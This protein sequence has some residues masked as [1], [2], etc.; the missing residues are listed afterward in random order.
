M[1]HK[2]APSASAAPR[3]L[4]SRRPEI[5]WRADFGATGASEWEALSGAWATLTDGYGPTT[6]QGGV[7]VAGERSWWDVTITARVRLEPDG[8]RIVGMLWGYDPAEQFVRLYHRHNHAS[9]YF[10]FALNPA[11]GKAGV[12][13]CFKDGRRGAVAEV[14]LSL[15]LASEFELTV[16]TDR[17]DFEA[18]LNGRCILRGQIQSLYNQVGRVGLWA[19]GPACFTDLHVSTTPKWALCRKPLGGDPAEAC[20][21]DAS[22]EMLRDLLKLP[23]GLGREQ[24]IDTPEL[25]RVKREHVRRNLRWLIGNDPTCDLPLNPRVK[26]E[27]HFSE[28][29]RREIRLSSTPDNDLSTYLLIPPDVRKPRPAVIVL[30]PT[31]RLG[32]KCS[33]HDCPLSKHRQYAEDLALRGYVTLAPDDAGFGDRGDRIHSENR[34]GTSYWSPYA[35]VAYDVRRMVDYL[36]SLP[37]VDPRRIGVMGHSRG[38]WMAAA[39]SAFEP[40]LAAVVV[41]GALATRCEYGPKM[42]GQYAAYAPREEWFRYDYRECPA[43]DHEVLALT[44]P[45]PLL[46]LSSAHD[47][48]VPVEGCKAAMRE[49]VKVYALLGVADR[50]KHVIPQCAHGLDA[51]GMAAAFNWFD[52]WLMNKPLLAEK[53]LQALEDRLAEEEHIRAAEFRLARMRDPIALHS[54]DF[55]GGSS[56][57]HPQGMSYGHWT[58]KANI[59]SALPGDPRSRATAQFA[60]DKTPDRPLDLIICGLCTTDVRLRV[61]LNGRTLFEKADTWTLPTSSKEPNRVPPIILK[62]EHCCL[63][64][65]RLA[66]E[67]LSE[68]EDQTGRPEFVLFYVTAQHAEG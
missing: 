46:K 44:A 25:W 43:D 7:A 24:A 26:E 47:W 1:N 21:V 16:M 51:Y 58:E 12:Y 22:P 61:S 52:H 68:P 48:H 66:I 37:E 41:S 54:T 62:P 19:D 9:L 34:P 35:Q 56:Q 11:E 53:G 59:I 40:R 49:V 60:I 38:G 13:R 10:L 57:E 20:P 63:G 55:A 15:P 27:V 29:V 18:R 31:L 36:Q 30:H 28:Y 14:P 65:N 32:K 67:N 8:A 6:P 23:A 33:A 2:T 42:R 17:P 45:R 64:P 39:A 3:S 5:N 4:G 50:V